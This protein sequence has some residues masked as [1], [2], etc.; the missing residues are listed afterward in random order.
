MQLDMEA[1]Y[2]REG[3]AP[4]RALQAGDG[5]AAADG[6]HTRS[7]LSGVVWTHS[8]RRMYTLLKKC[9]G[10]CICIIA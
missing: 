6:E 5:A 8:M 7:T 2:Q 3:D 4:L 1:V 9:A 10:R